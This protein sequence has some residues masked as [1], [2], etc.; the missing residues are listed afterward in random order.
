[1]EGCFLAAEG[2]EP[3]LG[4]DGVAQVARAR[5][6]A[7]LEDL[8]LEEDA[9]ALL[10]VPVVR[11]RSVPVLD[12]LPDSTSKHTNFEPPASLGLP[13]QRWSSTA[14]RLRKL[15]KGKGVALR[16]VLALATQAVIPAPLAS[17]ASGRDQAGTQSTPRLALGC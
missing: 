8:G 2:F 15:R 6:G 3:L 4:A 17:E 5:G 10:G 12:P 14:G 1:L 7:V 11:H 16:Q 13:P 9:T